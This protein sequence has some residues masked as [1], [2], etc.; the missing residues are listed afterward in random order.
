MNS[1][2]SDGQKPGVG[3]MES[4]LRKETYS[5]EEAAEILDMNV[6]F[7][8]SAVFREHLKA[9]VVNHDIVSINR[10]DLIDWMNNRE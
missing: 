7:I 8:H 2:S 6:R 3:G 5:P 1:N 4:L 9:N 10:S